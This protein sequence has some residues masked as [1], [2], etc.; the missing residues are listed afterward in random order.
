M[1]KIAP[2]GNLRYGSGERIVVFAY[3]NSSMDDYTLNW[4]LS[5][6]A[7][8]IQNVSLTDSLEFV[9]INDVDNYC[10]IDMSKIATGDSFTFKPGTAYNLTATATFT[11]TTTTTETS[12]DYTSNT[13]T[14][15]NDAPTGGKCVLY[16]NGTEYVYGND[17]EVEIAPLQSM[18]EVVC[19]RWT[20]S[21]HA[22]GNDFTYSFSYNDGK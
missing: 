12:E 8:T 14:L 15:L 6:G 4:T 11:T 18:L 21:D 10:I 9:T 17:T 20:D 3:V 13:L 1:I 5:Y 19:S 2:S 16:V 22:D 7:E